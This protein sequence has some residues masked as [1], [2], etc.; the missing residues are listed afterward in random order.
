[1]NRDLAFLRRIAGVAA[2]L[3]APL[4]IGSIVA[5]LAPLDFDFEALGNP[6]V[7]LALGSDGA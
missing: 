5:G 2:I 4:A 1:M 3:A 7:M 6:T